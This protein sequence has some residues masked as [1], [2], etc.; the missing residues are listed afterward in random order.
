MNTVV[1][2][3]DMDIVLNFADVL[4]AK[5]ER[6]YALFMLGIY[7]GLRVTDILHLKVQDV[8]GKNNIYLHEQK[9]GKE[10][11][12]PINDDLREILDEYT[13]D[14]KEYEYLFQSR[15]G[16]NKPITRTRAWDILHKTA[17]EFGLENIGC[18]TMRK[19]FGYFLYQQTK[20]ILLVKDI[21]NHADASSTYRYI[22]L[23]GIQK[24]KAMQNLSFRRQSK[25]RKNG[26]HKNN[27]CSDDND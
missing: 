14:M 18:H 23:M 4:R 8:R 2:I 5:S 24:D 27:N 25:E 15:Q 1:P 26:R 12:F 9:T 3:R 21:L 11:R 22:G 16:R 20:D 13:K 19:T 10:K 17:A 6:D 7:S